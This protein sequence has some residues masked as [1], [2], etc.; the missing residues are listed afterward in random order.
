[1]G[2]SCSTHANRACIVVT[3]PKNHPVRQQAKEE[4]IHM[5]MEQDR[6]EGKA[7]LRRMVIKSDDEDWKAVMEQADSSKQKQREKEKKLERR[8]RHQKTKERKKFDAQ[9]SFSINLLTM[10]QSEDSGIPE[11]NSDWLQ[12]IGRHLSDST[13]TSL[14]DEVTEDEKPITVKHVE[15]HLSQPNS[16]LPKM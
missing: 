5:K 16:S 9:G 8:W 14:A 4:E 6:R 15:Q 11:R 1:M 3:T 7:L 10:K 13:T 12:T 2:N